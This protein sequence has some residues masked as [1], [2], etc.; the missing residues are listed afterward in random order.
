MQIFLKTLSLFAIA[1]LI[2]TACEINERTAVPAASITRAAR[3]KNSLDVLERGRRVFLTRCTECHTVQPIGKYSVERW[4]HI[5]NWMA[6]YANL[7]ESDRAALIAY[8]G[9]ARRSLP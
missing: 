7:S 4:Q 8:L 1:F 3:G 2:I 5:A 9:S 6:P